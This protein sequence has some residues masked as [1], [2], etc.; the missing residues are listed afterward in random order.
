MRQAAIISL[1]ALLVLGTA[2]SGFAQ[3]GKGAPKATGIKV[4]VLNARRVYYPSRAGSKTYKKVG[5]ISCTNVLN[6][7]PEYKEIASK[8]I[9]RGTAEYDLLVKRASDRLKKAI[10]STVS[11]A[12]YDLIAETGAVT[13]EGKALPDITATVIKYLSKS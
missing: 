2:G 1:V 3:K 10:R 11:L 8:A 9:R 12:G 7:T 4:K 13:A 5:L 6:A